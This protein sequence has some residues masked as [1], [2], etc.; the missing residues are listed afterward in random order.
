MKIFVEL[1]GLQSSGNLE[2]EGESRWWGPVEAP[3]S[4]SLSIR[5]DCLG[6]PKLEFRDLG[7]TVRSPKART[8]LDLEC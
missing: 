6:F 7:V 8:I 5:W 2:K 3:G 4:D 1:S